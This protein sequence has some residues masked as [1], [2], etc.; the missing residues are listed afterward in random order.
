MEVATPIRMLGET[1]DHPL[2]SV[3]ARVVAT[4]LQAQPMS[5]QILALTSSLSSSLSGVEIHTNPLFVGV[6]IESLSRWVDS[7]M[8][9]GPAV[10]VRDASAVTAHEW[11]A[12]VPVD[13]PS[14]HYFG[15]N[16]IVV[17]ENIAEIKFVA[18]SFNVVVQVPSSG[19][20]VTFI[21]DSL[22]N[23]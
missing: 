18:N 23:L 16:R 9:E 1:P 2:S 8:E 6:K 12:L 19:D 13:R 20:V 10:V 17:S 7:G 14:D 11:S 4:S 3:A 22:A 21:I 15:D 5:S